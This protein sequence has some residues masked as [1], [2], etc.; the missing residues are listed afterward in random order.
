MKKT[1]SRCGRMLPATPEHFP[2]DRR[3]RDGLQSWC[4]ACGRLK[5][6]GWQKANPERALER[7]RAWRRANPERVRERGRSAQHRLRGEVVERLG[8]RCA[9]CGSTEQLEVDHVYGG[10][11]EARDAA[12]P[13]AELR[14]IRDA[15]RLDPADPRYQLLC[16]DCH[17]TKTAQERAAQ[18]IQSGPLSF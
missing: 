4:R 5:S 18:K 12:G 1:C 14:R 11:R 17:A 2:P 15:L 8:G 16:H 10:G 6:T 9:E 3:N 13:W 7:D